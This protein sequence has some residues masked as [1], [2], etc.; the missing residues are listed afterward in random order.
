MSASE[1]ATADLDWLA[2]A[3][4]QFLLRPRGSGAS[5]RM[6]WILIDGRARETEQLD[7]LAQE[8]KHFLRDE[9]GQMVTGLDRKAC[10]DA[11]VFLGWTGRV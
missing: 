5:K 4:A 10:S 2:E 8:V 9:K 1:V 3:H 11:A 7:T 6:L